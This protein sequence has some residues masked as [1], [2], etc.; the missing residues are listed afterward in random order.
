MKDD[1]D[2]NVGK[3]ASVQTNGANITSNTD[4]NTN[5][6]AHIW[7]NVVLRGEEYSKNTNKLTPIQSDFI[8]AKREICVLSVR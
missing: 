8:R 1:M 4:D 7:D 5:D 6:A 2:E 3:T